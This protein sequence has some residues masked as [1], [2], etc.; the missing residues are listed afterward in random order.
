[1]EGLVERY[2]SL[3]ERKA[4]AEKSLTRIQAQIEMDRSRQREIMSTISER[5]KVSTIEEAKLLCSEMES[6]LIRNLDTLESELDS[7]DIQVAAYRESRNAT[8]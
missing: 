1:M 6:A 8:S 2:K 3:M 4:E 5:Y 7:F